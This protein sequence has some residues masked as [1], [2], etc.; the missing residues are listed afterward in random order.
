MIPDVELL[1]VEIRMSEHTAVQCQSAFGRAELSE[2]LFRDKAKS[3]L[4]SIDGALMFNGNK[5]ITAIFKRHCHIPRERILED[6][7]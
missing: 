1:P 6:T 3:T 5:G 2:L 4:L 7:I